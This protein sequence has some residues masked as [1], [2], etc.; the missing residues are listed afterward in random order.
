MTERSQPALTQAPEW[1]I[2][3][4][5]P[6]Y[7]TRLWEIERQ[8]AE[9][10]AMDAIGRVLWETGEP[11]RD[12]VGAVFA[13]FKCEVDAAPGAA[14]PIVV[15]LGESRRLLLVVSGT[16]SPV[17]KTDEELAQAFREVQFASANDRVALVV[18]NDPAT[19]PAGRPD[20]AL[21]DALSVLQRMSVNVVT[22]ATLFKLWRLWYE[23]QQKARKILD[24]LHAQDGG[25]FIIPSR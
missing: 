8:S 13:V 24:R 20:P 15:R 25:P 23:D 2:A 21:P 1:M 10:R 5:P 16:A 3:E 4:M 22:T 9:L 14:G 12:A 7:Q 17:Q 18:N 11:L 19:P 6:G